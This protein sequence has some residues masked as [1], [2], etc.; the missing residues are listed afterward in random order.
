MRRFHPEISWNQRFMILTK[1]CSSQIIFLSGNANCPKKSFGLFEKFPSYFVKKTNVSWI[2]LPLYYFGEDSNVFCSLMVRAVQ[3]NFLPAA[4]TM[5]KAAKE[6]IW[7]TSSINSP[8]SNCPSLSASA[9]SWRE[10]MGRWRF[11]GVGFFLVGPR[12]LS[13]GFLLWSCESFCVDF[14]KSKLER[15]E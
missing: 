1:T 10:K 13:A 15:F 5:S 7:R 8:S 6:R 4:P 9:Y 3:R 14:K 12:K 11:L 2:S